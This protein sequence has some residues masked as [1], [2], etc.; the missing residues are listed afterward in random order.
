[1]SPPGVQ[2]SELLIVKDEGSS[3]EGAFEVAHGI[4]LD[5][6]LSLFSACPRASFP[7]Q[8]LRPCRWGTIW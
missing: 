4:L 2:M 7:S 5:L 1:V 3:G 6:G 8:I